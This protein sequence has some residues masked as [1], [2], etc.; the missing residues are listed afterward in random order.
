MALCLQYAKLERASA[1]PY[2]RQPHTSNKSNLILKHKSKR[3]RAAN[4]H[5]KDINNINYARKNNEKRI[6]WC[7]CSLNNKKSIE[8]VNVLE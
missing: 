7:P 2:A 1:K 3:Q 8:L 5:K 4:G 6:Y